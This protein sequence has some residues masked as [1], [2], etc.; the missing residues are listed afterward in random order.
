MW[1]SSTVLRKSASN[2]GLFEQIDTE[3]GGYVSFDEWIAYIYPH[4]CEKAATLKQN[5]AVSKIERSKDD[6]QSFIVAACQSRFCKEY[7]ELYMF[8]EVLHRGR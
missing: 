5:E 6:F 7:K 2:S 8:V 4:I 1:L 3:K